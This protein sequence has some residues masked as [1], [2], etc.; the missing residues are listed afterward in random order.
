MH[1]KINERVS[2]VTAYNRETGRVAPV[3]LR[4]HGRDYRIIRKVGYHHQARQGRVWVHVFSVSTEAM[5]FKLRHRPED[6]SWI[7]EEVSDGTS[8]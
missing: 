8:A 4:W 6:L 2:V 1:E 7:L 3:S 5:A